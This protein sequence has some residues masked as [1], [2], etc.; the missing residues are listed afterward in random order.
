MKPAR[1]AIAVATALL[2][3]CAAS[4][5]VTYRYHMTDW[6]TT[7]TV[8]QT[9]GCSSDG[10]TLVALADPTVET[11]YFA[12]RDDKRDGVIKL[13]DVNSKVADSNFK[14]DYMSDGRL[15][16]INSVT[17]GQGGAIFKSAIAAA[18]TLANT[19]FGL[20]YNVPPDVFAG[21]I[22]K[23][24]PAPKAPTKKPTICEKVATFGKDKPVSIVYT[25]LL[26]SSNLSKQGPNPLQVNGS[27][28]SI[29][30]A[31]TKDV[32]GTIPSFTLSLIGPKEETARVDWTPTDAQKRRSPQ[33]LKVQKMASLTLEIQQIGGDPVVP[34]QK[35]TVEY[36]EVA[37]Y[38]LP[39]P[40][41]RLFG[42]QT[43]VV[44]MEDSGRVKSN[45]Y[46]H[47]GGAAG[48]VDAIQEAADTQTASS[49]AAA[50]K[51]QS[52]LIVQQ[53]RRVTC[54]THPTDCK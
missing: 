27:Y 11:K 4:P 22:A 37:T 2:S 54:I 12:N 6:E 33:T 48:V 18:A 5:S 3:G 26:N 53:Q 30:N 25:Y 42:S 9:L 28:T 38:E 50:L 39:I 36:P 13:D 46:Q 24:T 23:P 7:V 47:T 16:G 19:A 15:Q 41:A 35:A 17:T 40:K 32:D 21:P 29:Y 34:K 10:K 45:G 51:D 52:D 43:F 14:I 44:A 8:T 20:R 31:L 1:V 49:K